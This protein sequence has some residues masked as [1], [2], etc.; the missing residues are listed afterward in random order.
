M[1]GMPYWDSWQMR[2]RLPGRM[3]SLQNFPP[4]F[5]HGPISHLRPGG[6]GVS[7]SW[8]LVGPRLGFPHIGNIS[9]SSSRSKY[10]RLVNETIDVDNPLQQVFGPSH[11]VRWA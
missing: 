4:E 6:V 1:W 7:W 9:P 5:N 10:F 8:Y 11:W 2:Q 3:T